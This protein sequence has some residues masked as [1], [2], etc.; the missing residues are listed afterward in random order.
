MTDGSTTAEVGK[1]LAV[2]RSGI[3]DIDGL[4]G[5]FAYQWIRV[6]GSSETDIPGSNL[7]TH[8]LTPEDAGKKFKVRVEFT[9]NDGNSEARTSDA[10]PQTG[11]VQAP[12][13]AN[14]A[15]RRRTGV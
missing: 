14:A 11:T 5:T 12:S 3:G 13:G 10:F 9:D 1:F 8:R 15:R 2:S 7:L 4:P 6:N